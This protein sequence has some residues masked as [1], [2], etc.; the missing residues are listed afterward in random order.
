MFDPAAHLA[1][2][3]ATLGEPVTP[4]VGDPFIGMFSCADVSTLDGAAQVG[5]FSLRY[6]ATAGTFILGAGLWIRGVH[7]TVVVP[8]ARVGNGLEY[9]VQLVEAAA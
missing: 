8:S 9:V 1:T 3:Y 5:D 7:Y 4:A 6:P 2:I